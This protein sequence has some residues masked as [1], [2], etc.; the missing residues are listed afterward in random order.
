VLIKHIKT[1]LKNDAQK[2]ALGRYV[3]EAADGFEDEYGVPLNAHGNPL[4]DQ[5]GKPLV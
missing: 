4:T 3:E 2:A 1:L 5:T